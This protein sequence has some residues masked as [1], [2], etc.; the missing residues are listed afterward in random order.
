MHVNVALYRLKSLGRHNEPIQVSRQI[1]EFELA[2]DPNELFVDNHTFSLLEAYGDVRWDRFAIACA[3]LSLYGQR[4]VLAKGH[5]YDSGAQAK[6]QDR[7]QE[8]RHPQAE[9]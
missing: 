2:V 3:Y 5:G 9:S 1:G 7:L 6:Q 4:L 8:S